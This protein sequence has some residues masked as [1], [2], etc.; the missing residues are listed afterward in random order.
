MRKETSTNAL[1]EKMINDG[2]GMALSM[3]VI[4][5]RWKPA[6]LCRLAYGTMR[7]GELK[8][9]IDGISERM[10]VAQLR[11]MEKDR[12]VQRIVY[13]EVPP[14]VEYQLTDLGRTMKP[15]LDAMSEW[16]N[17]YRDQIDAGSIELLSV[18]E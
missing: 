8:K 14:R 4:G 17:K 16:G 2:C 9:A 18:G 3:S 13:P 12:I 6:I 10:L 1:N 5:G 7:Y 11:E 15:M